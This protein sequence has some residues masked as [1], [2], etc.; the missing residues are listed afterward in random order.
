MG[1]TWEQWDELDPFSQAELVQS[2]QRRKLWEMK[3]Q[4]FF[5]IDLLGQAMG[6]DNKPKSAAKESESEAAFGLI[7]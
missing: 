6:G 4:A 2:Y 1:L 7:L 5:T 3:Q